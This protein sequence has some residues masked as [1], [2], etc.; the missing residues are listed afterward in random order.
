[1]KESEHRNTPDGDEAL[2]ELL[3]NSHETKAGPLFARNVV[4]EVRLLEGEG[5]G[6]GIRS[7]WRLSW[8][9]R[10]AFQLAGATALLIVCGVITFGKLNTGVDPV[11]QAHSTGSAV[12]T[13]DTVVDAY[14]REF[15]SIENLGELMA[16]SDPAALSDEALLSLLF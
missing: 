12:V 8:L 10:P 11:T 6:T 5:R 15:E 4:R 13:E 16:V 1:M 9:L 3:G 14:T 2:W 7:G